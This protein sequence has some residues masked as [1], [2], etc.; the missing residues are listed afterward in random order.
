MVFF[1]CVG[2]GARS[3]Y[4]SRRVKNLPRFSISQFDVALSA[5]ACL[6]AQSDRRTCDFVQS[7]LHFR[8][9]RTGT[10]V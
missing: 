3:Q 10:L 1:I 4:S 8:F 9:T 7:S 5:C 6:R 2:I